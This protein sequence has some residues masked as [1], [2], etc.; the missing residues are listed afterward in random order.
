MADSTAR[1]VA[2]YF[3]ALSREV[4]DPIT[5]LKLQKLLFYAQGW[6]LA[7]ND[8]ALFDERIEAWPHGPVVPPIYGDFKKWGWSPIGDEIDPPQLSK[9]V[10]SHLDEVMKVFGGFTAYTLEQMTH[11]ERPWIDARGNL[12]ADEPSTAIITQEAMKAHFKQI[13]TTP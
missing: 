8:R 1:Q 11:S 7:L 4:G 6:Y 12:P 2:D 10:K 13:A 3:I 5:N 9:E